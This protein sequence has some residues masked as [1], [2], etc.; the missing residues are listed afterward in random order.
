MRHI[1]RSVILFVILALVPVAA[2]AQKAG[3][4]ADIE[5][6]ELVE[7]SY[8]MPAG[9]DF[10]RARELYG[11]VSFFRPYEALFKEDFAP[12]FKRVD[13]GDETVLPEIEKYTRTHFPFVEVHSRAFVA[14]NKF[15][16]KDMA[17]YHEWA[18]KGAAAA[19]R[20]QGDAR[21]KET[22]LPVLNISEE[23]L[24]AR[25]I[26]KVISQR[27]THEN[28]RSYDVLSVQTATGPQRSSGSM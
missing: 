21:S 12:L 13:A 7:K 26:G 23:Y 27:L 5:Y 6:A 20:A 3:S 15:G 22:A 11:K 18:A 10:S 1:A 19:M 8:V 9:F 28:E 16:K 24:V 4:E 14:Y 2:M 25:Q 17:A